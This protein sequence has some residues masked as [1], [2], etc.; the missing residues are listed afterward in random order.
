MLHNTLILHITWHHIY[1][2][3]TCHNTMSNN[4]NILHMIEEHV[5]TLHDCVSHSVL[6][7]HDMALY[8]WASRARWEKPKRAETGIPAEFP[9]RHLSLLHRLR[10]VW[11]LNRTIAAAPRIPS[12]TVIRAHVERLLRYV[13]AFGGFLLSYAVPSR[14]LAPTAW[15]RRL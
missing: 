5:I 6:K 4:S 14:S 11:D 13:A 9:K 8:H 1:H 7:S 12:P 2:D 15:G 10:R 3:M